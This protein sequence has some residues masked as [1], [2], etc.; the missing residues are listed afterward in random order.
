[1]VN[2]ESIGCLTL[3]FVTHLLLMFTRRMGAHTYCRYGQGR[4]VV[5]ND[6]ET[7]FRTERE[8]YRFRMKQPATGLLGRWEPISCTVYGT[9]TTDFSSGKVGRSQAHPHQRVKTTVALWP[10]DSFIWWASW[11][12]ARNGILAYV[13]G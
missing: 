2:H 1:M 4:H 8:D 6:I 5:A 9:T 7:S 3:S 13:T 10:P 12:D 11:G